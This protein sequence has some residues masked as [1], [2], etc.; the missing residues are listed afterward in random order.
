MPIEN[1][2][3]CISITGEDGMFTLRLVMVYRAL[4]LQA[5]TGMKASRISATKCA[6]E[7]G[8]NGRAA[9]TLLKDILS[10]YPEL[11]K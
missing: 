4:K 10:K 8:F 5:E 3:G 9:K 1:N 2:N 11:A 7:M 6:Q